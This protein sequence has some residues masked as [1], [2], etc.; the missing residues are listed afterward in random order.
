[1]TTQENSIKRTFDKRFTIP[2]D[3]DFFKHPV[4]PYGLKE[5]LFIR[6]E[7]NSAKDVLLWDTKAIYKIP[8]I[9]LE[10]DAIFDNLY[11]TGIGKMYIGTMSTRT[12]K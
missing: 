4:Y 12:P 9:F 1:M 2:L 8:D 3:F 10:N 7:L 11:A 5:C 6:I